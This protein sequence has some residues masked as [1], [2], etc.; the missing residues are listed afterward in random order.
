[1]RRPSAAALAV[2]LAAC[3]SPDNRP[4]LDDLEQAAA[5]SPNAELDARTKNARPY[6]PT[7]A[8]TRVVL[9]ML[10]GKV[11]IVGGSI[12]GVAMPFL[13]DTGTSHVVMS[14]AAARACELYLPPGQT[15]ALV[16]PGYNARFRVGAPRSLSIGAATLAGGV[17]AIPERESQ[18]PQRLGIRSARHATVGSAVLSNYRVVLDFGQREVT[19]EP[20][21]AEPFA[22]VLWT[23]VEV[24]GEKCR[25]LVDT[26]ANGIFLEPSFARRLGLIDAAEEQR[27]AEKASRAGRARFTRVKLD[28]LRFGPHSFEGIRAH[29]VNLDDGTGTGAGML[30][31]AALG[32]HR[33]V[34]DYARRRLVL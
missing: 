7:G 33:W 26:G 6:R 27:H 21:G 17:A 19:L 31:I 13:L 32:P 11:P 8:S 22:G 1:M 28:S 23:E 9:P 5:K 2:L 29:V 4:L 3:T 34:I 12:N 20:H 30:G 15:V 25:L 10:P 24:N 14:G 18:L 16:T